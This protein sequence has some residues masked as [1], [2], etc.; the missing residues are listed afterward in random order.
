MIGG[1]GIMTL[2]VAEVAEHGTGIPVDPSMNM[3]VTVN[4]GAPAVDG[5]MPTSEP[6]AYLGDHGGKPAI[7]AHPGGN[8]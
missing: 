1:G 5:Y 6:T 2:V 4:A 7:I 8:I 3:A